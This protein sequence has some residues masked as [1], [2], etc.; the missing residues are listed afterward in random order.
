MFSTGAEV[1]RGQIED[2]N[3][4]TITHAMQSQGYAVRQGPILKD[5]E[6]AIA[7][8]LRDAIEN[9]GYGLVITT[10]GVGAE[11]KD[12]TVEAVLRLDPEAATPYICKFEKGTGRHHKDGVKIA[13]G[14]YLDVLVVALPGPNDEVRIGLDKLIEGLVNNLDKH[15]LA[16]EIAAKL[17]VRLRDKM[18]H[19]G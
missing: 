18:K 12:R 13:V 6:E 16:E 10:G 5:D 2:T 8:A 15:S 11:D 1:A 17:R 14:Q 9:S 7:A 4:A 19:H 3:M